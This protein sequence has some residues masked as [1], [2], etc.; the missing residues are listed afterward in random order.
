MKPKAAPGKIY[1]RWTGLD[2]YQLTPRGERK[3]LCRCEC[4]A[5][6]YV[7]ERGLIYG[8]STSCGCL[9]REHS[10]RRTTLKLEGQTFGMLTVLSQSQRRAPNGAVLW[11]CRCACGSECE[12]PGTHLATGKRT[13]C[14]CQSTCA[15]SYTDIT[16]RV[17]HRLTA[18]Y[19]LDK[20][21]N[22]GYVM[23]RCRCTCGNETEVSYN[24]LVYGNVK[25]CGCRKREHNQELHGYLTHVGGT[26]LEMLRSRKVPKNN[27]T[28]VRGVYLIKG[29]Y[30]AKIVFQKKQYFLG[31]FDN[32]EEAQNARLAAEERINGAAV[33]FCERWQQKA[34]ADPEWAE[35]HPLRFEVERDDERQLILRCWPEL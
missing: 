23:W 13:H 12:V 4:G 30:V 5:Q 21:D 16:G 26:S 9:A 31:T 22:A 27:T 2:D 7:L 11:H 24:A 32:L 25:S 33:R 6:R 15:Y 35:T 17:F 29:K 28:G 8:G 3:W 34:D 14:G 19:P 18:L 10:G 1:G 20:R